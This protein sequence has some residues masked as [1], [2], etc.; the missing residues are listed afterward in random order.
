MPPEPSPTRASAPAG[1]S[2]H[3]IP[4]LDGLR[5]LSIFLVMALH[6]VQHYGLEHPVSWVWFGIFNGGT[7]VY[8]FFVISGYLITT[9]LLHEH[10]KKGRISLAGFYIRRAFRILPPLYLYVAVVLLLAAWRHLHISAKDIWSALFFFHNYIHTPV[11]WYV[12]HFWSLSVEEQFYLIWPF[13]VIACLSGQRG[14]TEKRGYKAL[15]WVSLSVILLSPVIRVL[16][17]IPH[18]LAWR[19]GAMFHMRADSLMFGCIIAVLQGT[20]RF[21]RFYAAATRFAWLPPMMLGACML[22]DARLGSSWSK[23]IGETLQGIAIAICLLWAVRNPRSLVGK[24]LNHRF[25][26]WIGVLSYSL[27]LWQTLFLHSLNGQVFGGKT[28]FNT[29]PGNWISIF[30]VGCF[31]YYVVEQPSL[32]LRNWLLQRYRARRQQAAAISS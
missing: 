30:A 28:I 17:S 5:A 32:R 24:I 2:L 8:V 10:R 29:F 13:V 6:S 27:Y 25:I 11:G 9:L 23:P 15:A 12:E 3:R 21:E 1:G 20:P 7:G 19:D 22:L 26:A 18:N 14:G 4:S 31:S 16:S